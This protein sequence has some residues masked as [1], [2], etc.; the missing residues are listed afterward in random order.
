[1]PRG[2]RNLGGSGYSSYAV[3]VRDEGVDLPIRPRINFVGPDV[4]AVDDPV[5][6]ETDVTIVGAAVTTGWTHNHPVVN[7]TDSTDRV[8]VGALADDVATRKLI[9]KTTGTEE[10]IRVTSLAAT[11]N[12]LDARISGDANDTFQIL[13]TATGPTISFGPGGATALDTTV[14]R[15]AVGR[16]DLFSG[17]SLNVVNGTFTDTLTNG[18]AAAP[19][20]VATL[21]HTAAGPLAGIG[22][23]LLFRSSYSAGGG[24]TQDIARIDAIAPSVA[25]GAEAG[26]IDILTRVGGGGLTSRWQFT[27]A[28]ALFPATDNLYA[29]GSASNRVLSVNTSSGTGFRVFA[30]LGDANPIYQLDTNGLRGGAG[31]AS[32]VDVQLDR[33]AA[34]H[35]DTP[36]SLSVQR[37]V[38]IGTTGLPG[39]GSG[40]VGRLHQVVLVTGP[41]WEAK[42][43][44]DA[45]N[46]IDI[47]TDQI[48]MGDG[49][50]PPDIMLKRNVANRFDL[51]DADSLDT[52]TTGTFQNRN[53]FGDVNPRM[54]LGLDYL[55]FG[56]GGAAALTARLRRT[57]NAEWT[58]DDAAGGGADFIPPVTSTGNLGTAAKKWSLVRATTIT[59]GDLAF[60]DPTCPECS[61]PFAADDDLVLHVKGVEHDERGCPITRTVPKH[62]R[63]AG[64]RKVA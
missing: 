31:G 23:S 34:D 21:V 56:A 29:I 52:L 48:R 17:T 13:Q 2:G 22:T 11:E 53:A 49:T 61:A 5:N 25:G 59:S 6:G 10:G 44:G 32:V 39:G 42:V 55:S 1:M 15:G 30:A 4:T 58:L 62:A 16:F 38:S 8:V 63:C 20:T 14:G 40:T 7:L 51:G 47:Q 28:G 26:R 50:N 33:F 64:W 12:I 60:D 37:A 27:G 18:V 35:W 36:D 19:S 43:T 57:A 9:V 24:A 41:V 54:E 45:D 3:G 46:R